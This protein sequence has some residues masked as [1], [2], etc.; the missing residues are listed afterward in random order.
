MIFQKQGQTEG[1]VQ[2]PD[3]TSQASAF[4][5][6]RPRAGPAP[7]HQGQPALQA[8]LALIGDVTGD[9]Q[10]AAQAFGQKHVGVSSVGQQLLH[11]LDTDR[12]VSTRRA[13]SR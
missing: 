2:T 9:A 1:P 4:L 3:P 13:P 6:S 8:P 10:G 7:A 11:N 5:P 12:P